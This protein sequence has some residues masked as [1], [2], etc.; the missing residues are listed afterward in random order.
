M[1]EIKGDQPCQCS[2]ILIVDDNEYNLFVLQNY[3]ASVNIVADE[4]L[5]GKEAIEAVEH[6]AAFDKCCKGYRLI[7]MDLNMPIMDGI[8]ATQDL[9]SKMAK[10]ELLD[11]PIVALTAQPLKEEDSDYFREEVGFSEYMTKPTTK[12]QFLDVL[13]KFLV[14]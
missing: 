5:N 14:Y 7:I 6:K 11:T 2:R 9:K 4:A 3:M 1:G 8:T 12:D 13:K 10:G